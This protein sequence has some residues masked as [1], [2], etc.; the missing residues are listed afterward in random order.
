MSRWLDAKA[1]F[2]A[3]WCDRASVLLGWYLRRELKL[4]RVKVVYGDRPDA[5]EPGV[6]PH[7]WLEA[8]VDATVLT[9]DITADQFSDS[10]VAV[11]VASAPPWYEQFAPLRRDD[12]PHC[13]GAGRHDGGSRRELLEGRRKAYRRV[14]ELCRSRPAPL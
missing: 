8:V 6:E 2:P 3:G 5:N 14:L 1:P 12:A 4:S 9:I 10:P 11:V 7:M 13:R